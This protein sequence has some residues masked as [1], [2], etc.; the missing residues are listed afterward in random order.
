MKKKNQNSIFFSLHG[1]IAKI[2]SLPAGKRWEYLWEYYKVPLF[3][4][5]CVLAVGWMVLSFA[6]S[7]VQGTLFPKE[8]LSIAVAVPGFQDCDVWLE[9][10]LDA[11]AYDDSKESMQILTCVPYSPEQDDFVISS[12]LWFTAGQPDIFLCDEATLEYLTGLDMLASLCDTWPEELLQLARDNG[13][14][15]AQP[16]AVDISHT[17]FCLEHSLNTAPVYLC[18]NVSGAG[19]SRALDIVAYL[20]SEPA[21]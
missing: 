14:T 2:R 12:T 17:R 9:D 18:M 8:P 11:I 1:E 10:C 6:V 19:F 3:I 5:L 16:Y 15:E 13:W 20:L 21:A 7:A 4:S